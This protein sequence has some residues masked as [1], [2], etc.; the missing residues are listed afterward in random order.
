[1][2]HIFWTLTQPTVFFF[3]FFRSI[4][5]RQFFYIRSTYLIFLSFNDDI[6]LDQ[7]VYFLIFFSLLMN[8]RFNNTKYHAIT[9]KMPEQNKNKKK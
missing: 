4:Y 7:N 8:E 1:M 2:I 3:F 9:I 6:L 5:L